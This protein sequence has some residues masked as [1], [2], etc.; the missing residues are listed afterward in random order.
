MYLKTYKNNDEYF[1]FI[2]CLK[3][4]NTYTFL[5]NTGLDSDITIFLIVTYNVP[6]DELIFSKIMSNLLVNY[7][8]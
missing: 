1:H 3:Y 4:K 6:N 8:I 7:F 2:N 5:M